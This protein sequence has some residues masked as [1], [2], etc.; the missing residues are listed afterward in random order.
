MKKH[1]SILL[2][3]LVV[4]SSLF[5]SCDE[6]ELDSNICKITVK[7]EGNGIVSITDYIGT[8]VNVLIGNSVEVVATPNE[9]WAFIGWFLNDSDSPVSTDATFTFITSEDVT[10]T[11]RFAKLSNITIRSDGNGSVAFKDATENSIPFLPGTEVTVIA[12]PDDKAEFLGWFIEGS[13]TAVC[14]EENYS[15]IVKENITLIG[16]FSKLNSECNIIAVKASWLEEH[17]DILTRKPT[18]SQNKVRFYVNEKISLESLKQLDPEFELSP[19]A[20]IEKLDHIEE[21]LDRGIDLYYRTVS[22]DKKWS[23][24]YEVSFTKI[25]TEILFSFEHFAVENKYYIWYEEDA[26]GTRLNWWASG[27][28]GFLMSGLG[29]SPEDYPTSTSE[30]GVTGNCVKLTTRSTGTFGKMM[31]MPIA[32]GNI[33]IGE[34]LAANATKAPLEATRFGLAI[35]PSKPVSLTGYYKYTPGEVFTDKAMK[36]IEGR[37]DT[38][39]IYSVLYEID[40]DNFIS[41]DG[42]NVLSS[43]RIV[44]IAEMQNPGEP[45]EWERFD[46]LFEPRNGKVFDYDKLDNNEYAIAVVASSSK[47]GAFFEGAVGSTLLIDELK[48]NWEK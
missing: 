6:N 44:L 12:T 9:G 17:N 47:D 40:P 14:L 39:S 42:S 30:D 29:K 33:F 21:N 8:S 20:Q 18:I 13:E 34:F 10:L 26:N 36:E 37:V 16:K 43:D 1:A 41:L 15:L 22:E 48:I 28:A 45:T 25:D 2:G 11:A 7:S 38:C 46:I 19:G 31:N 5:V 32:A 23:K 24:N 35:A 4:F 3:L 27:N